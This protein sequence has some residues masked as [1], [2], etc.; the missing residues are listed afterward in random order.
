MQ[1]KANM[2]RSALGLIGFLVNLKSHIFS[3]FFT[4]TVNISGNILS[5]DWL[6]VNNE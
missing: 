2:Q 3:T 5:Y 6:I 4:D 1:T